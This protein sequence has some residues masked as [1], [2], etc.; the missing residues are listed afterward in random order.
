MDPN[1]PSTD[2]VHPNQ[3]L[4]NNRY[5]VLEKL[6]CGQYS[7]V[8]LVRD[9]TDPSHKA[10]KILH[11]EC[12]N[13][14]HDDIFELEIMNHLRTA[15]PQHPGYQHISILLDDFT[16]V[17]PLGTHVCL[18]LDLM[19]E[20]LRNFAL[21][22][23]SAKIPNQ[24]LKKITRQLLLAL[25]YVHAS[26][27]IHT[28][29]KQSN[30]MVRMRNPDVVTRYLADTSNRLSLG[31]YNF[32][33]PAE[34]SD[35]DVVLC[36]WGSA[37]WVHKHLTSIIQPV[38]LRAPEVFVQAPWG[39]GVDIWNLGCLLPELLDT[40]R[41]FNGR[42]DVTGGV[43]YVKHHVEEIDAL[44]GPFPPEM[45]EAGDQDIV[46]QLFD[47]DSQIRDPIERPPAKLERWIEC[48]DG[49]EKE[50]F[51]SML[52][53]MLTIDPKRRMTAQSLQGALWLTT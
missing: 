50:N 17:S 20:D 2:P 48:L 35:V 10:I 24:I 21:F 33:D 26:G 43:Y 36:D 6:G 32:K 41:M 46:Q 37:S 29:I 3:L 4:H 14:T 28:D 30:I 49:V 15:N 39:I 38:L 23:K 44:F 27:V 51:L 18:V 9:Q 5:H 22:F 16:H 25:E 52:R 47:E 31:K 1:T 11:P 8:W 34:F 12:Y 53:S 13:S 19:A 45:L 7:T 42:A 40:V